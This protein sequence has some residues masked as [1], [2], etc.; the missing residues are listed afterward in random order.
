MTP[1][2]K[3]NMLKTHHGGHLPV[4]EGQ[5]VFR[6]NLY[7]VWVETMPG[8]EGKI[9]LTHLSIKRNGREPIHDWRDLQAIKNELCGTE[10]EAVELYPAESRLIDGA[11][12]YH[13]WVLPLG[14]H[15]P[16]GFDGGRQVGTKAEAKYFGA[17]QRDPQV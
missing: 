8:L 13:L 17:T 16:V 14:M 1:L 4:P 3:M 11:N 2:K 10:T 15:W 9:V 6:N 5:Q 7:T 12:Q